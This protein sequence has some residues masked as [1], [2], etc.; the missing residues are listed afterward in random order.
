MIESAL[1][2][3]VCTDWTKKVSRN[4]YCW[5]CDIF[6]FFSNQYFSTALNF[7][8]SVLWLFNSIYSSVVH[9]KSR[10]NQ[11]VYYFF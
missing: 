8:F 10:C 9:C 7:T 1:Y 5:L 6:Y 4:C 2:K 3:R 11:T